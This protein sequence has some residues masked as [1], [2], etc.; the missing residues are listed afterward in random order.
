ML[1]FAPAYHDYVLYNHSNDTGDDSARK[2]RTKT[3]VPTGSEMESVRKNKQAKDGHSPTVRS[4][5]GSAN[6]GSTRDDLTLIDMDIK[7][8]SAPKDSRKK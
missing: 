4:P 7:V 5:K 1:Q 6:S 2:Y 8:P 3:F